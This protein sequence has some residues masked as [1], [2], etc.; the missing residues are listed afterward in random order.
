[1]AKQKPRKAAPAEKPAETPA[2][3]PQESQSVTPAEQTPPETDLPAESPPEDP[4]IAKADPFGLR[5]I[6]SLAV[7]DSKA[8]AFKIRAPHKGRQDPEAMMAVARGVTAIFGLLEVT[9]G[10][11]DLASK[12]FHAA[13]P[14]FGK[15]QINK[16]IR[17]LAPADG[18]ASTRQDKAVSRANKAMAK[19]GHSLHL[20]QSFFDAVKAAPEN[21]W[22]DIPSFITHSVMNEAF[23]CQAHSSDLALLIAFTGEPVN[24]IK[25]QLR[26]AG[27]TLV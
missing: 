23:P 7:Y 1:M 3:V 25:A 18:S 2:D 9:C 20:S 6:T 4:A 5:K 15:R 14:M 27:L 10:N 24:A 19:S 26:G 11:A 12:H 16:L 8:K 21:H 22:T 13:F 17:R